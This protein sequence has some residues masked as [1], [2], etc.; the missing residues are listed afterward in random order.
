MVVGVCASYDVFLH[1]DEI[2]TSLFSIVRLKRGGDRLKTDAEV[3][4]SNSDAKDT[5]Q[6]LSATQISQQLTPTN[7]KSTRVNGVTTNKL[8]NGGAKVKLTSVGQ[9][10]NQKLK[11]EKNDCS[12]M[13]EARATLKAVVIRIGLVY[14]ALL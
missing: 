10:K 4:S 2:W 14:V 13:A 8:F 6:S 9:T 7:N 11:E 1:W 3:D 12:K 5:L